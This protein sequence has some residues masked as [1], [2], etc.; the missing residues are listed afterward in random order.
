MHKKSKSR[1]CEAEFVLLDLLYPTGDIDELASRLSRSRQA[2]K[3]MAIARGLSGKYFNGRGCPSPS[4]TEV[5]RRGQ[6]S[7]VMVKVVD[8]TGAK[9]WVRKHHLV[10]Q[11]VH[12]APPPKGTRLLFKDGDRRNCSIDNLELIDDVD[13]ARRMNQLRSYPP[14][15]QETIRLLNEVRKT[16]REHENHRRRARPPLQVVGPA[17]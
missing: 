15:L 10:W 2:I 5:L 3:H 8:E 9:A 4:G 14:A 7:Y 16:I 17:E 12:G 6:N 1:W 13:A 11:A